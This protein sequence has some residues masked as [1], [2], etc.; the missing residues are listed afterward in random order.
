[1]AEG[2]PQEILNE[3]L[4]EEVYGIKINLIQNNGFNL[5]CPVLDFLNYK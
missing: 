4:I 2:K 1:V 5:I 3:K